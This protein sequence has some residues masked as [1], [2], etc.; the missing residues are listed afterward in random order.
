M[1]PIKFITQ[2]FIDFF[3]ITKPS[4]D[5][6]RNAVWIIFALLGA[7]ILGVA[8]IFGIVVFAFGH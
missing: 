6:E 2:G 3:G 5:E 4:P 1:G 8:A 7:V